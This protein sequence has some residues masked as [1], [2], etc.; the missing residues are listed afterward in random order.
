VPP[1]AP[2]AF[3]L[4]RHEGISIPGW[5]CLYALLVASPALA[6]R[7]A[8]LVVDH[9]A[10]EDGLSQSTVMDILQ[11]SQGFLW[12]ATENG[13]D[14]Y[15]GYEITQYNRD[16]G[17]PASLS[18]DYIWQIA[19][20]ADH[21]LWLATDGG[22][23]VRWDRQTDAFTSY[24]HDPEDPTSIASNAVRTVL[25]ANDGW[26]WA[27]TRGGG[28]NR[29][30]P[31]SGAF[32]RFRQDPADD[33]TLSADSVVALYEDRLG[34]FWVGTESGLNRFLPA[35]GDFVRYHHDADIADSLSGNNIISL[36]ED[37]NGS[38]WV[39]TLANGVNRHDPAT[40]SFERFEHR[41]ADPASL[42]NNH[43]RTVLEDNKGR[44]WIGTEDGLNLLHRRTGTFT[45]YHGDP[46]D[47]FSL[48]DSYVMALYQDRGGVL[49]IGTRGAGV[50]RWNPRSWSLGHFRDAGLDGAYVMAFADDGNGN[51]WVGTVG[52]G[53]VNIHL[54]TGE[55]RR[56]GE[57]IELSDDRVMSLLR[58][59]DGVLWVGTLAGGLNRYDPATDNLTV[60]R[61]D[62]TD[63]AS[64]SADGVM[65]LYE[66]RKGNIWIGTF[67]GGLN[68]FDRQTQTFQRYFNGPDMPSDLANARVT[69]IFEDTAGAVWVGT[70]GGGLTRLD[71]KDGSVLRFRH[72]PDDPSSLSAD[73]LYSLHVD[74]DGTL[75]AGTAGGGLDRVSRAPGSAAEYVF[76]NFSRQSGLTSDVI[77]GIQPDGNGHLWLS[78][79]FGLMSFTPDT[80]AVKA[81][82]RS[83][84]LQGEEFNFGA[85]HRGRDGRMYFGGNNGFN[86][87]YPAGIEGGSTV[88][89][90]ALTG[91]KILNAPT[92]TPKPYAVLD[93][94]R[95]GFDDDVV[96]FEF[97]AL[98]FVAPALNSYK[99]RLEGFDHS[100]NPI[101]N[102]RRVTYTDLDA[103]EYV[104]QVRAANSDGLW[105]DEGLS[106]AVS[107]D[108]PPWATVWAYGLYA[109]L[110]LALAWLALH[111]HVTRL[112]REEE[113]SRRLEAMVHERT[114]EL[115]VRND[116]LHDAN[117]AKSDFLAKMSHEIRTPMN[118][119]LGMTE[120]LQNTSLTAKQDRFAGTIRQSAESLLQIINDILDFSKIEAGKLE[121]GRQE[122]EFTQL[123][124]ETV[125]LLASTADKKGLT[126]V[127]SPPPELQ[128]TV[129][130][131]PLRLRQILVNLIGNAI[132]FTDAGDIVVRGSLVQETDEQVSIKVEVQDSGVGIRPERR[133]QIF[134]SF[135]QADGSAVRA[136][137]GTG[138]GLSICKQLVELMGGRIGVQSKPGE[139]STFWFTVPLRKSSDG[140]AQSVSGQPIAGMR[141]LVQAT[142]RPTCVAME[143][144]F[145]AWRVDASFVRTAVELEQALRDDE[146][147]GGRLDAVVLDG[148]DDA[149]DPGLEVLARYRQ[150]KAAEPVH[151]VL[152]GPSHG[153][154]SGQAKPQS[155]VDV[156]LAKPLRQGALY[157]ALLALGA[158]GRRSSAAPAE[159]L[160]AR[161]PV[162]VHTGRVLV[163]EDNVVNQMVADG[164]LKNF[165]C[166]VE[167]AEDGV[168]ALE[169]VS[170]GE[171]DLVLM[172]CLMPVMDGFQAAAAIRAC[173]P[174]SRRIPIVALTA[175]A[176][177]GDR[178]RC[179]EAGMDD[180]L[181]KPLTAEALQTVLD[182]WL[183][184]REESADQLGSDHAN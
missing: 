119:V 57:E 17:N 129:I 19:E 132:K 105:N 131:D 133:E 99:Y 141:V 136:A 98:D 146:A 28:L 86:A 112:R 147:T 41:P 45:R 182:R 178:Q 56:L 120:L 103:G 8:P 29:L 60:F 70:D 46:N 152:L 110:A 121:L 66:D 102:Q 71:V 124:D 10:P 30:D 176:I 173:E 117:R 180:Y 183:P 53:L 169:R 107:V 18:S 14:R 143:R 68:R 137:S 128:S 90:L 111:W 125:D 174:A 15:D 54:G 61:A 122:F 21:N 67:G 127:A 11:D 172:D 106:I 126:L 23:L 140:A 113:N 118:G 116:E 179:L 9:I 43:V 91:L 75:W 93:R 163:V 55:L 42:S 170:S 63:P 109:T 150:W 130:G 138:L 7:A 24:R 62:A 2:G 92:Q 97:A 175:N 114:A 161:A 48:N 51:T 72:D 1:T 77:Y 181:S 145:G 135:A 49:W 164:M 100:W 144:I 59:R 6:S 80:G 12:F 148:D 101:G 167:I 74:L 47:Q 95:L 159:P 79:N 35:S 154:E 58:A 5:I 22:G 115:E 83:H 52:A 88:P 156:H 78:G 73:T 160:E 36:Y 64:L 89:P 76:E 20:D 4:P 32:T 155:A 162:S 40:G 81:Y 50:A 33:D 69:T 3:V 171:F 65:S 94:L 142:H 184:A 177:E 84:G 44:L 26:V 104:F 16:R 108:P 34:R 39:G 123:V 87:F 158:S 157:D 151:T 153:N 37:S 168:A 13:L 85:H 165:G 38:L 96:T 134:D 166:E 149:S 139:G 31:I 25:V 82:H 27:G